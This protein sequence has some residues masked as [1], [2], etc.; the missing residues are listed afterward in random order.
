MVRTEEE[1]PVEVGLI[2]RVQVDHLD[3]LE[4]RLHQVLEQLAACPP[5][6]LEY[7]RS[8]QDS[9]SIPTMFDTRINRT[10]NINSINTI[11]GTISNGTAVNTLGRKTAHTR[12]PYNSSLLDWC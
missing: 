6:K 5:G 11:N 8:K 10:N 9:Q 3:V 7:I 12:A 2:D 1:L 4:T